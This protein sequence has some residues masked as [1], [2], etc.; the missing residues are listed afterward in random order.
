MSV[1]A[2]GAF[3]LFGDVRRDRLLT[4][5][6]LTI[7]LA[8]SVHVIMLE[9][10]NAPYPSQAVKSWFPFI[11]SANLG[12][13]AGA[14]WLYGCLTNVFQG[15]SR[16]LPA[17]ILFLLMGGI[18]ETLRGWFMNA[19]CTTPFLKAVLITAFVA[20]A[21]TL[22]YA[23]LTALIALTWRYMRSG[24][25]QIIG[26]V[27]LGLLL[28]IAIAALT[29]LARP[30]TATGAKQ[31]ALDVWCTMPYGL[32]VKIPAYATFIEP[33]LASLFCAAFCWRY[34]PGGIATK[35]LA[36]TV[37]ILALKQQLFAAFVYV[38]YAKLPFWTALGSMGQ[39]SLEA[40]ALGVLTALNWAWASQK[41]DSE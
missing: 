36:F 26:A 15:R 14:V 41:A 17:F 29:S 30:D 22:P 9:V 8:L 1:S 11:L 25:Q 7:V 5:L 35:V 16:L 34:L 31:L 18:S 23:A 40:A 19:Y 3:R 32:N 20:L 38:L 12:L 13:A 37:L 24:W 33:T 28:S 39:F 27:L 4:G 2:E 21:G 10:L 6:C